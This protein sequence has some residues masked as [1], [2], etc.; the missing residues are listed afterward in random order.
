MSQTIGNQSSSFRSTNGVK[1]DRL[2][3]VKDPHCTTK[4]KMGIHVSGLPETTNVEKLEKF[5]DGD[6]APH[7][8]LN[9]LAGWCSMDFHLHY[10]QWYNGNKTTGEG[11]YTQTEEDGLIKVSRIMDGFRIDKKHT[12]H[13]SVVPVCF[14]CHFP[15]D[16]EYTPYHLSRGN[17]EKASTLDCNVCDMCLPSPIHCCCCDS[18]LTET[19]GPYNMAKV[20]GRFVCLPCRKDSD[21]QEKWRYNKQNNN[22]NATSSSYVGE[23]YLSDESIEREKQLMGG[24]PQ[25]PYKGLTPFLETSSIGDL[26][27]PKSR[28]YWPFGMNSQ[29]YLEHKELMRFNNP[30]QETPDETWKE[31]D[32][33]EEVLANYYRD[34]GAAFEKYDYSN[35]DKGTL[36]DEII[37][38]ACKYRFV[39]QN[40]GFTCDSAICQAVFQHHEDDGGSAFAS[41]IAT[42]IPIFTSRPGNIHG[43]AREA[44]F[45]QER[46]IACISKV[47]HYSPNKLD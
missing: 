43:T 39:G 3:M 32:V 11:V 24:I 19:D 21:I 44:G 30:F 47:F 35:D 34:M 31:V 7:R 17:L 2:E 4:R 18:I 26:L 46:C 45:G 37:S 40:H 23:L 33:T 10:H 14:Y 6:K 28:D 16:C 9:G 36:P 20:M 5:M 13:T 1:G 27:D 29:Q 25:K 12:I 15:L 22:V 41:I 42:N 38:G 8:R